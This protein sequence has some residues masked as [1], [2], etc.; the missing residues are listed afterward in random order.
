M[1][2]FLEP[3]AVAADR[4]VPAPR[5][6]RAAAMDEIVPAAAAVLP[7]DQGVGG[8]RGGV[9]II[10]IA[11]RVEGVEEEVAHRRRARRLHPEHAGLRLHLAPAAGEVRQIGPD[12]AAMIGDP[13]DH[14]VG[15]AAHRPL[16]LRA[17]LR[18]GGRR[19]E[20]GQQ[21]EQAEDHGHSPCRRPQAN[22]SS[23]QIVD[24]MALR[25]ADAEAVAAVGEEMGFARRRPAP[26]AR[27]ASASVGDRHH[28]SSSAWISRQGGASASTWR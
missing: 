6:R 16:D 28:T 13:L 10:M 25:E 24:R 19:Q 27:R 4:L 21:G 1:L 26:G 2:E 5:R 18:R 11:S 17:A 8:A 22:I 14:E 7:G 20:E 15:R 9:V 23:G 3:P 12:I